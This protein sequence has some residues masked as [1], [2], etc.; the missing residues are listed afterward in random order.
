MPDAEI[1]VLQ[2]L[3]NNAALQI[4]TLVGLLDAD[5]DPREQAKVALKAAE[6]AEVAISRAKR[7]LRRMIRRG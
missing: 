4:Q 6:L 5:D 2:V 7:P 1:R 3:L